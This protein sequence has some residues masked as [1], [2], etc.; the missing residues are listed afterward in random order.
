MKRLLIVFCLLF[1]ILLVSPAVGYTQETNQFTMRFSPITG[2]SFPNASIDNNVTYNASTLEDFVNTYDDEYN[3][4]TFTYLPVTY[5]DYKINDDYVFFISQYTYNID[6]TVYSD[7]IAIDYIPEKSSRNPLIT[8]SLNESFGMLFKMQNMYDTMSFIGTQY[9]LDVTRNT[10]GTGPLAKTIIVFSNN[11][12][13]TDTEGFASQVARTDFDN[14]VKNVMADKL[15]HFNSQYPNNTQEIVMRSN[16]NNYAYYFANGG[17]SRFDSDLNQLNQSVTPKPFLGLIYTPLLHTFLFF[18]YFI[19]I[20]PIITLIEFKRENLKNQGKMGRVAYIN[21]IFEA[22]LGLLGLT[23]FIGG[24]WFFL[25][26]SPSE[27]TIPQCILI[28]IAIGISIV[29]GYYLTGKVD[30]RLIEKTEKSLIEKTK[31]KNKHPKKINQ[32]QHKKSN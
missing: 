27:V 19:I 3:Q 11:T 23:C 24:L 32:K 31:T 15:N 4:L 16:L 2:M 8:W 14:D 20:G 30:D 13:N 6:I 22:I 7:G 29:I 21:H 1:F 9:G 10:F 12:I 5:S 17:I 18:I 28:C 25:T 26:Q